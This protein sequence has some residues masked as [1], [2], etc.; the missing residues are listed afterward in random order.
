MSLEP[1]VNVG[2]G[3]VRT[4]EAR[5]SYFVPGSMDFPNAAINSPII[6]NGVN[7]CTSICVGA[8]IRVVG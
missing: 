3:S 7:S 6:P 4:G 1:V 5:S 2:G 8:I